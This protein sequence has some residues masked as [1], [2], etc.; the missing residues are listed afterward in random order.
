MILL[1]Y[2]KADPATHVLKVKNGKNAASGR[3]LSFFYNAAVTSVVAIPVNVQEAH[4]IFSLQS[5]DF[6]KVVVQG[7]LIFKVVDAERLAE[8]MNFTLKPNGEA[9]VSEDPLKLNDKVVKPF[10]Q[11]AQKRVMG[12]EL[13]DALNIGAALRDEAL[14][15][16]ISHE[17]LQNIGIAVTD[18][19]IDDIK[20]NQET[21]RALEAE[22]REL[23]LQKADDAIYRRRKAAVEQ[24]GTIK[25][26]ELA[27]ELAVQLK[28]QEIARNQLDNEQQ[29]SQARAENDQLELA[30]KIDLERVR[31]EQVELEAANDH[32]RADVKAYSIKAQL[33]AAASLPAE[34]LRMLALAKMGPGELIASAIEQLAMNA[35][36]VGNINFSPELLSSLQ[37]AQGTEA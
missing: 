3:G 14:A 17:G 18:L 8:V 23:L 13:K 37:Q 11:I 20:P 2:Y 33:E 28:E 25:D 9:Y 10:Q 27:N 21:Q 34:Q 7:Q 31:N 22:A 32:I 35:D 19:I 1:N 15:A 6:Q 26:A 5:H 16:L 36:K 12:L 30:A 29:L 24:E 4:Y